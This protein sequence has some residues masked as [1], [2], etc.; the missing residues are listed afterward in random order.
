[1]LSMKTLRVAV[2]T[3]GTALLL[4]PGFA[5]AT[6]Q[7]LDGTGDDMAMPLLYAAE[8]VPMVTARTVTNMA[9]E[10]T[11]YGLMNDSQH[12]NHKLAAK[13]G[14]AYCRQ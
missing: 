7:E 2:V 12:Q 11:H 10:S 9:G 4:G 14:A 13:P 8:T 3:M 5:A 1:M 6:V